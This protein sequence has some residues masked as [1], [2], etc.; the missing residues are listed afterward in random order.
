MTTT[1]DDDRIDDEGCP[2]TCPRCRLREALAWL[3][4]KPRRRRAFKTLRDRMIDT[5]AALRA[6]ELADE[7]D[8][9]DAVENAVE[10]LLGV[11]ES[12]GAAVQLA[13]QLD[14]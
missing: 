11:H 10:E 14:A 9:E 7:I 13:P 12:I 6:V 5:L 8:D 3:L 4:A 2:T 1:N